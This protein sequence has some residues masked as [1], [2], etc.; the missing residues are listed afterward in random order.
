MT[1]ASDYGKYT[2]TWSD[3][4]RDKTGAHW[5]YWLALMFAVSLIGGCQ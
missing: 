2:E 4:F 5:G 3:C 1:T